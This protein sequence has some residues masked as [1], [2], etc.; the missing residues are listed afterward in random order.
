MPLTGRVEPRARPNRILAYRRKAAFGVTSACTTLRR[1]IYRQR[2]T[3][4]YTGRR[5]QLL[6]TRHE[7]ETQPRSRGHVRG[8][9]KSGSDPCLS[10]GQRPREGRAWLHAPPGAAG[11]VA[12]V[13]IV[14]SRKGIFARHRGHAGL[15][16]RR[17]R[18]GISAARVRHSLRVLVPCAGPAETDA[19]MPVFEN[20]T[21]ST[22]F[23]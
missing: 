6:D 15:N 7:P 22:R 21:Q 16:A 19:Q 4:R 3:R 13:K 10:A 18:L 9:R 5:V 23:R 2:Y 17:Y 12:P 1:S 11:A 20:P 14:L 8:Q